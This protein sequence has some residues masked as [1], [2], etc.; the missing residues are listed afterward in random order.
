M[1]R[2]DRT[3]LPESSFG[4]YAPLQDGPGLTELLRLAIG[5]VR[6]Q[7]LIVLSV[8]FL[9]IGVG[10]TYLLITPPTFTAE[11]KIITD[12]RKGQFLKKQSVLADA[13]VD[14]AQIESQLEVLRSDVVATSV[15][16]DLHL[17]QDPEFIGPSRNSSGGIISH[18]FHR[19]TTKSKPKSKTEL[20]REA[21]ANFEAKL[22]VTRVLGSFV[23]AISFESEN[24]ERA[25]QIANAVADHYLLEEQQAEIRTN[26]RVGGWLEDR[27]AGLRQQVS[28]AD[29]EVVNFAKDHD[30]VS[31]NGKLINDQQ[32]ADLNSQLAAARGHTS[33]A[34]ARLFRI[35]AVNVKDKVNRSTDA[36]VSDA[37]NDPIITNMRQKYL[38]LA[39]R[40]NEWTARY[41]PNHQAVVRLR[42]QQRDIRNSIHAE[43][44]RLAEGYKSDYAIA[45]QHE[46][47]LQKELANAVSQVHVSSKEQIKLSELKSTAQSY[48]SLYDSFLRQYTES[49]EQ[50]SFPIPEARVLSRALPPLSKSHPKGSLVLAISLLAGVCMGMGAGI[51]RELMDRVFRTRDQ[52][53]TKLQVPCLAMLPLLDNRAHKRIST[54]RKSIDYKSRTIVRE[55]GAYWA[56]VDSPDSRFAEGIRSIKLSLDITNSDGAGQQKKI[57]GFTSALPNEGKST[58]TAAVAQLSAQV[59]EKV[60]VVDCD[61]RNPSLSRTFTKNLPAGLVEVISGKQ[62][63]ENVI[64]RDPITNMT[65]LPAGNTFELPHTSEILAANLTRKFFDQLRQRYDSVIIDLPPLAPIVDVRATIGFIDS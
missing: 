55:S 43:L 40:E 6:R 37:L 17:T 46:Q 60:I 63:I 4:G 53:E 26:Q 51:L 45:R 33:Q 27:L 44:E 11:V 5:F 19:A 38:E 54:N 58:I 59:G 61:L 62:S 24:P 15:I 10:I 50:Q 22:N 39:Q 18:I 47:E 21:I 52:V 64:W 36:T 2:P 29:R 56:L 65:F 42:D 35:Q 25:A 7:Y 49:V 14:S 9:V 12:L 31:A 34:L 8:T 16:N 32:L 23:I 48:H 41:G 57:I 1:L 13:P 30:I 20:T 28:N 3:Q